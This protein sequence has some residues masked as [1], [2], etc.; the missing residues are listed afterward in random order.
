MDLEHLSPSSALAPAL[1]AEL[2]A[3]RN[4][5]QASV[6][7]PDVTG[8]QLA[9]TIAGPGELSLGLWLAR[10][11]GTLVGW[12]Q[13]AVTAGEESPDVLLLRGAVT[14]GRQRRGIG[15]ALV[16]AALASSDRTRVRARAFEGTG[17]EKALPKL[18]F[19][20]TS[21]NILGE[22][23]LA[24]RDWAGLS[25]APDGYRFIRW[26]G[27]TPPESLET[28]SKLREALFDAPD[29]DGYAEYTTDQ[30]AQLDARQSAKGITQYT[31]VALRV[32]TGEPA[33]FTV[34][35]VDDAQ[36]RIGVQRDTAVLPE[37]RGHRLGT[38][39][40]ADLAGWLR[41]QRPEVEVTHTWNDADNAPVLAVN[42]ALGVRPIARNTVWELRR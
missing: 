30:I 38:A 3:V 17:G 13:A 22:L 31:V 28:L 27:P 5:T 21:T 34:V 15:R 11:K 1:A 7:T 23:R 6:P 4:A 10:E 14:P 32:I 16:E 42:K 40:K 8:P 33:A 36:P 37:H 39:L 12:T 18:G 2:A 26:T 9:A 20:A 35:A 25:G 24:S 41:R 29:I 19:T